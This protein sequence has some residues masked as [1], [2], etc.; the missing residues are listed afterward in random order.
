MMHYLDLDRAVC[1]IRVL[2][3]LT[4][5]V[6]E[7]RKRAN[8]L[9]AALEELSVKGLTFSI[10]EEHSMAG[11]GSLPTQEIPTVVVAVSSSGISTSRMEKD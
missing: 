2:L 10:M 6:A 4:E 5:P 3:S 9:L 8:R 11:G 1:D 7:V